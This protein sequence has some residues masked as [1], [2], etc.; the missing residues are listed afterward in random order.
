MSSSPDVARTAA[1]RAHI[2]PRTARRVVVERIAAPVPLGWKIRVETTTGVVR[3]WALGSRALR[4]DLEMAGWV[5]NDHVAGFAATPPA[6][7]PAPEPPV[8]G[9]DVATLNRA[10]GL[11]TVADAVSDVLAAGGLAVIPTDTVYG[12]VGTLSGPAVGARIAGVM[13]TCLTPR[14][15]RRWRMST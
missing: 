5:L 10:D 14:P 4:R 8:A 12:L 1:E 7:G 2:D 15:R 6:R 3:R 11:D 9:P 13:R